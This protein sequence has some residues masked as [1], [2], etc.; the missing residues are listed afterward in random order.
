MIQHIL[1]QIVFKY[2][3]KKLI[4]D[5]FVGVSVSAKIVDSEWHRCYNDIDNKTRGADGNWLH[6]G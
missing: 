1:T 3:S 2:N 4:F 6:V 5:F